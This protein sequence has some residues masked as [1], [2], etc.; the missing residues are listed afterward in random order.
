LTS[1]PFDIGKP[2]VRSPGA[3]PVCHRRTCGGSWRNA[4]PKSHSAAPTWRRG[5]RTDA[6]S[7]AR[8]QHQH[9]HEMP[10]PRDENIPLMLSPTRTTRLRG[11][12]HNPRGS[13]TQRRKAHVLQGS[14]QLLRVPSTPT[15]T[16]A[17]STHQS[18]ASPT[19]ASVFLA[20]LLA[21]PHLALSSQNLWLASFETSQ[22][23]FTVTPAWNDDRCGTCAKGDW[24]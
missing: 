9:N 18:H 10:S 14:C 7:P 5:L 11:A 23:N 3:T 17:S 20:F 15:L 4:P 16:P 24:S 12:T 8:Q 13:A 1:Y 2:H 22:R 6:F 21:R 19:H